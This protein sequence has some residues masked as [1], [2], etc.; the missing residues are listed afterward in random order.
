MK[1]FSQKRLSNLFF[2]VLFFVFGF[3]INQILHDPTFRTSTPTKAEN[4]F[5]PK[6]KEGKYLVTKVLDGDTVVLETGEK[7]RYLGIDAPE[8]NERWG[9]EAKIL[10]EKLV[11][12]KEV[13][14]ELD[15]VK[16]DNYGRVLGYIWIES[17]SP[18]LGGPKKVILVNETLVENGY[19]KTNIIKG[20]PKIKYFE[21]IQ[22][23]EESAHQN[24]NGIWFDEWTKEPN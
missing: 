13:L 16:I 6:P 9:P 18:F 10:N 24:H 21:R 7:F 23:A 1:I 17:P 3:G 14:I 8:L 19:A 12:N 5:L 2:A 15:K 11:L 22:K 4:V 20:E